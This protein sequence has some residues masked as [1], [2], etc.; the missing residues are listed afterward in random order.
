MRRDSRARPVMIHRAM[1]GSL[2]RFFGVYVE[3]VA[4]RFPTWLAPVQVAILP[5]TDAHHAWAREVE[6]AGYAEVHVLEGGVAAWQQ[7][8]MPVVK[9][10]VA[11]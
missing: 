5:I 2:E 1:L 9:Q 4:G 11:K 10:G 8:G 3:H 6:A 7:A